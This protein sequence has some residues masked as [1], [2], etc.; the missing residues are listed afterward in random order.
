LTST[1][2]GGEWSASRPGR[3]TPGKKPLVPINLEV[4]WVPE[5]SG[6]DG[7]VKNSQP[8]PELEPP[9]IQPVAI[10][11]LL[12]SDTFFNTA[13]ILQNTSEN[14]VISSATIICICKK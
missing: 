5:R 2:N 8:L 9:I 14:N 1:L 11:A 4:W 3:F 7:E 12:S 13:N 10:P 6:C